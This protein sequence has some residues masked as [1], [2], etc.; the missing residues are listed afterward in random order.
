MTEQSISGGRNRDLKGA[1]PTWMC[2]SMQLV[3]KRL[4]RRREAW[5]LSQEGK[6]A[7]V[8]LV[9]NLVSQPN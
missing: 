5:S 4:V 6:P 8:E 3:T 1:T 7:R 2:L 9:L